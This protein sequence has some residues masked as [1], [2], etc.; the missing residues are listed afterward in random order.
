[1]FSLPLV[2]SRIGEYFTT[3]RGAPPS[4]VRLIVCGGDVLSRGRQAMLAEMWD[5]LVLNMFGCSELF[6]P[7]AGPG[8][9]GGPMSWR[10]EPV[11]VEVLDPVTL[12]HC[13]VGERGVVVLSTLWPKASPLLRYWTDD[14]VQLVD[15]SPATGTFVFE[16]IGRPPSMLDVAGKKVPLRDIDDALL[17]GGWCTSEWSVHQ[18]PGQLRIEAETAMRQHVALQAVREVLH[19]VV[20]APA[21]LVPRK[22]GALPRAMPKFAVVTSGYR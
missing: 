4:H 20:G 22:P 11:A 3:T 16:Y 5:A 13:G 7:V 14:V 6:G 21:D 12:A 1:M 2:A 18:A 10:C 8:E 17:S 15:I 19:E 9:R